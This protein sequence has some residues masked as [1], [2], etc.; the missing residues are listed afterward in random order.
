VNTKL[1]IPQQSLEFDKNAAEAW[2]KNE[3]DLEIKSIKAKIIKN[4]RRVGF[5]DFRIKSETVTKE[6][7]EY[8]TKT[9]EKYA[10]FF[11]YKPHSSKRWVYELNKNCYAKN[12]P[13]ETGHFTPTW[14]KISGNKRLIIL[15]EKDINTFLI[16]DDAAYSGEQIAHRQI[17]PIIKFYEESRFTQ[18]PKFVLA[19]PFVTN[20]FLRL[21]E[22]LKNQSGCE[23]ILYTSSIMPKLKEILTVK[24]VKLLQNKRDGRLETTDNEPIYLNAT[25][26]YFDHRVADDHSFSAEVKKALNLS[27]QKTYSDKT[28]DYFNKEEQEF[29]DYKNRIFPNK[30]LPI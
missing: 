5:D 18:K 9:K 1:P 17:E 6:A 30:N 8:L 21:I 12:P 15:A 25:L 27:A 28:S 14:E 26:T 16:I 4:I 29:E 20:R 24:E 19:I 10:V 2:V 23:I 7:L 22:D 11:D 13:F 3:T